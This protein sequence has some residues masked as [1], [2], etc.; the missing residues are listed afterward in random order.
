M[1]CIKTLR[2]LLAILFMGTLTGVS[3]QAQNTNIKTVRTSGNVD[4]QRQQ[5][6]LLDVVRVRK[7]AERAFD[8]KDLSTKAIT[9]SG[10]ADLLWEDDEPHARQL[11]SRALDACSIEKTAKPSDGKLT[12]RGAASIRRRVIG[13]ISRRDAKWAKKLIDSDLFAEA[14]TYSGS[15]ANIET[16][17]DLALNK[18]A[19]GAIDFAERS[20]KGGVSPWIVGLLVELRRTDELRSD[21]LFL[22]VLTPLESGPAADLK[23][24][25]YLGTYLFTS[26]RVSAD[27]PAAG[28]IQVIVGG[29]LVYDITLD[30]PNVRPALVRA[31]IQ[32]AIALIARPNSEPQSSLAYVTGYLLLPKAQRFAPELAPILSSTMQA[33]ASKVPRD[34]LES[35]AYKNLEPAPSQTL[36]EQLAEIEKLSS[37]P[38]R[39][40]KYFSLVATL[41]Q[42]KQ[43]GS[44]RSVTT[45]LSDSNVREQLDLLIDFGEAAESLSKSD[46][47]RACQIAE[48]MPRSIERAVTWLAIANLRLAA[49]EPSE[50]AA[51]TSSAVD[52]VTSL[53]DA[54]RGSVLLESAG[55]M[56]KLNAG[57]ASML[58]KEAIK[59]F[60]SQEPQALK[61]IEWR[62]NIVVGRATRGFSLK[63]KGFDGDPTRAVASLAMF[64]SGSLISELDTL[65]QEE[66][67][68]ELMLT[69]GAALLKSQ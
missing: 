56:A 14:H 5:T 62:R 37:E 2:S 34:L 51:A 38:L 55:L 59:E 12:A 67:R 27:D 46:M 35:A 26:P 24:F 63:T 50:A 19:S 41:W 47:L 29:S 48:K 52:A 3:T 20:L 42:K 28:N 57:N 23:T 15:Q 33:I 61:K 10:L 60:N 8:F 13:F 69:I 39:N 58:L 25:L 21:S 32:T 40:E 6:R 53:V 16:A 36:E 4:D 1:I 45:K 31:Y 44:A 64:D 30:R 66:Q 54:R 22:R 43:Y 11:F 7:F 18:N 68:A 9:V 17:Y 49:K 65:T